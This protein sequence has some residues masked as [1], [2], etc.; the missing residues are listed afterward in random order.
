MLQNW[1]RCYNVT[2][3]GTIIDHILVVFFDDH[4]KA[5]SESEHLYLHIS[6]Q[7]YTKVYLFFINTGA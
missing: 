4:S 5:N 2:L 6:K 1:L 7:I 3:L